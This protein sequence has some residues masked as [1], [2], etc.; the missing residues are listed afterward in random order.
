ML[1][2]FSGHKSNDQNQLA[3][4]SCTGSQQPKNEVMEIVMRVSKEYL[5]INFTHTQIQNTHAL[6][7]IHIHTFIYFFFF[8]RQGL[9]HVTVVDLSVAL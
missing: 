4:I 2:E 3:M 9:T 7:L 1:S 8:W 6:F 5:V